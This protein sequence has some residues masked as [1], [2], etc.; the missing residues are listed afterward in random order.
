MRIHRRH[1]PAAVLA[2]LALHA[3]GA[4]AAGEDA[5]A[6]SAT[7][8]APALFAFADRARD[9]GD[10][11]AAETA[12]RALAENPDL[13]LRTEARFRLALMLADRMGKPREAAVE[14]R[15]ILDEKPRAARVRLELAR[16]Q[17]RMGELGAAEREFRAVEA[18]T[19]LPPEVE[20]LV[21]FYANA[22]SAR[23]PFGGSIEL[24]HVSG[25]ID[26]DTSGGGITII[27]AGGRV[28]AD[29]S[30]GGI[31]ASFARGN[32]LG[33]VL[34][35]SGGGIEVTLDPGADLSIEASGNAVRTDLPLAVRGEVSRGSLSGTLGKGG[36]LLRMHTSGGSVRIQS[37]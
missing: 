30:G 23:K 2:S 6:R 21:R 14:L 16:L 11:A 31:E 35:T 37:L 10:F 7:L 9:A 29:T 36:N 1:L 24:D 27:E 22:L 33:G 5:P 15:R 13:E 28:K 3:P 26:A 18:A 25:D 32:S 8:S 34:E 19:T 20:R 17:A 4:R 12:Y